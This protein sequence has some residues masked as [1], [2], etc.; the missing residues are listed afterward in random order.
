MH[1]F[2]NRKQKRKKKT[3]RYIVNAS[4]N[5]QMLHYR[6]IDLNINGSDAMAMKELKMVHRNQTILTG[7]SADNYNGDT[8]FDFEHF[9][10]SN[11][12]AEPME[13]D[14]KDTEMASIELQ[15]TN[16]AAIRPTTLNLSGLEKKTY[17]QTF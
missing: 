7:G 17:T 5:Q 11:K 16:G 12:T 13:L 10:V 4:A 2:R 14:Q 6:N 3:A 8:A 15:R 9:D 1:N